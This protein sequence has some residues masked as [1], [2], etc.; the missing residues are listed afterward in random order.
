[1]IVQKSPTGKFR[2]KGEYSCG[3]RESW[4]WLRK[5]VY[6]RDGFLNDLG[7]RVDE[8]GSKKPMRE[9]ELTKLPSKFQ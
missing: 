3:N 4:D 1:M 6:L 2:H 8:N 7:Q 5:R 9:T